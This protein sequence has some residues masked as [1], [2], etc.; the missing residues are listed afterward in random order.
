MNDTPKSL[1]EELRAAIL[2]Y[3]M[4]RVKLVQE[5]QRDGGAAAVARLEDEFSALCKADLAL[6]AARLNESHRQYD[7]LMSEAAACGNQLK[8]AIIGLETFTTVLDAMA[9]TVTVVGRV[10]LML[11]V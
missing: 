4:N 5:A 6:A 3:N 11:A 10:L 1:R 8:Q 2:G 9:Q 7:A